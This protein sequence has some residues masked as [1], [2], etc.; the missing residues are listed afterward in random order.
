VPFH[1][2]NKASKR[3]FIPQSILK[4]LPGDL[5]LGKKKNTKLIHV[6][7]PICNKLKKLLKTPCDKYK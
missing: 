3:S 4:M 6:N 2:K 5:K 1:H 7:A